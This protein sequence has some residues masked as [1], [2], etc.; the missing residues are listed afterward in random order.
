MHE[1][2]HYVQTSSLKSLCQSKPT[3]M[4]SLQGKGQNHIDGLDH[5]VKMAV[6]SIYMY[7]LNLK[8]LQKQ[9]YDDLETW[10][11]SSRTQD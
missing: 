8:N 9:K 10:H 2:N 7:D 11:A 3:F 1:Y 6:M 5:M 4:R